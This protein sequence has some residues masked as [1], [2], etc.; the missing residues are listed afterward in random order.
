MYTAS[1]PITLWRDFSFLAK[2]RVILTFVAS[3]SIPYGLAFAGI[4]LLVYDDYRGERSSLGSVLK[5]VMRRLPAVV[6]V[7]FL[8][9]CG[10][11]FG[12]ILLVPGIFF[13][14]LTVFTV[15]VLLL[16][17]AGVGTAL[18]R[19][20][21]MAWGR[22][23]T[24]LGLMLSFGAV[25]YLVVIVYFGLMQALNFDEI[26]MMWAFR[27]LLGMVVPMMM[28]A[29]CTMLA[30]LYCDIRVSHGELGGGATLPGSV[31]GTTWT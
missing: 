31:V 1:D 16:E 26:G 7:S 12:S 2:L 27:A 18:R 23:G 5:R 9:G 24:V 19:S 3:A 21:R 15:P 4:S 28:C 13:T 6:G 8:V 30:I 11:V 22:A 17:E 29:Y 20:M 10:G 25:L 14:M